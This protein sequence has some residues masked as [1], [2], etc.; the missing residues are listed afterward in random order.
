MF[1]AYPKP[2]KLYQDQ[3]FTKGNHTL[4]GFMSKFSLSLHNKHDTP[5]LLCVVRW[6]VASASDK[7]IDPANS[8]LATP[9][10]FRR[11]GDLYRKSMD[12][13]IAE[14]TAPVHWSLNQQ[15]TTE[16]LAKLFPDNRLFPLSSAASSIMTGSVSSVLNDMKTIRQQSKGRWAYFP[17]LSSSECLEEKIAQF[18]NSVIQHTP[19]SYMCTR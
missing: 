5:L 1:N 10:Q 17:D 8:Q 7:E 15:Q 14:D 4:Y 12:P 3:Y 18:F 16:F 13:K 6:R 19:N 9:P 11:K 2:T